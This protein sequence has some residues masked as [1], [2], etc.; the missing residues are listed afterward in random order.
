[1]TAENIRLIPSILMV[2]LMLVFVVDAIVI[3]RRAHR[4]RELDPSL[5]LIP[6]DNWPPDVLENRR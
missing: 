2:V 3:G 5:A 6:V 4:A 1:M